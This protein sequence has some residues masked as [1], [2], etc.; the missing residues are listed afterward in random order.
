MCSPSWSLLL[1]PSPPDPSGSSQC[2]RPEHLSHAF[3]LGWWSDSPLIIYM[4]QC[5]SLQ[6]SH[7]HLLP[8]SPKVCSVHLCLFFCFAYK[9]IVIIFLNSISFW[10]TSLCIM[11]SSFIHLWGMNFYGIHFWTHCYWE[12]SACSW[13]HWSG[14]TPCLETGVSISEMGVLI[15]PVLYRVL[16]PWFH[17]IWALVVYIRCHP[18]IL[19]K[20]SEV[21]KCLKLLF[22]LA[23]VCT[24]TS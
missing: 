7:P 13:D 4:F 3:D 16:T 19:F 9:V 5:C 11:G 24:I 22:F 18:S 23:T 17:G 12:I 6:T 21:R 14:C 20:S 1:P 15:R 8:Q 2:T 10:L